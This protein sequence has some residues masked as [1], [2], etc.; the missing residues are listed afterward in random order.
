MLL[1]V[2]LLLVLS[3]FSLG[4]YVVSWGGNNYGQLGIGGVGEPPY[5]TAP[6]TVVS[7]YTDVTISKIHVGLSSHFAVSSSGAAYCAGNNFY[8]QLGIDSYDDYESVPLSNEYAYGLAVYPTGPMTLAYNTSTKNAYGWGQFAAYIADEAGNIIIPIEANQEENFATGVSTAWATSFILTNGGVYVAGSVIT[9]E[10]YTVDT[11]AKLGIGASSDQ[12]TLQRMSFW[13]NAPLSKIY[14][15]DSSH[16]CGVASNYSLYCW[17]QNNFGQ[18]GIG[19]TTPAKIP[20]IVPFFDIQQL[21]IGQLVT[22]DAHTVVLTCGGKVYAWGNNTYGNL[23]QGYADTNAHPTP[24]LISSLSSLNIIEIVSSMS[25]VFARTSLNEWYVWGGS[26]TNLTLFPQSGAIL[27]PT[28]NPYFSSNGLTRIATNSKSEFA[29]AWN[30]TAPTVISSDCL[31]LVDECLLGSDDCAANTQ[32]VDTERAYLCLCGAGFTGDGI[33]EAAGGT[34]CNDIDE[35]DA[36][37]NV[38]ASVTYSNGTKE[39]ASCTNTLGSYYCT[40]PSGFQGDG[41]VN[42]TNCADINECAVGGYCFANTICSNAI[43]SYSCVCQSGFYQL[44]TTPC[45][46]I[47]V[48]IDECYTQQNPCPAG[49]Y[50]NNSAGA[51]NCPCIQGYSGSPC[52]DVNE[53]TGV[54]IC[55]S[56]SYCTNLPGTY[57]CQ[58]P[59][60]YTGD[61]I[62][63]SYSGTGCTDINECNIAGTCSPNA[64]CV[65]SAGSYSC[66]CNTGYTGNGTVCTEINECAGQNNCSTGSTCTNIPGSYVCG[67]PSGYSGNGIQSSVSGGTGCTDINECTT[68]NNCSSLATCTNTPGSYNCTCGTNYTGNGFICYNSSL[69]CKAGY[70]ANAT[71]TCAPCPAGTYSNKTNGQQC[72]PCPAGTYSTGTGKT[73]NATCVACTAN[74]YSTAGSTQCTTCTPGSTSVGAASSCTSCPAGQYGFQGV[75]KNCGVGY[76][77]S[78]GSTECP[79]CAPGYFTTSNTASSC[80]I[81]PAGTYSSGKASNCS[82]CPAGTYSAAGQ[83]YCTQCPPGT[84]ISSGGSSCTPCSPGYYATSAG[85]TSCSA[86]AEGTYANGN[87][88][89]TCTPCSPGTFQNQTGQATCMACSNWEYTD[90]SGSTSCAECYQGYAGSQQYGSSICLSCPP[91]TFRTAGAIPVCTPCYAGSANQ[92]AGVAHCSLCIGGFYAPTCGQTICYPA[93]PGT[94]SS[95]NGYGNSIS[96]Y[97]EYSTV[98]FGTAYFCY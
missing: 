72:T 21:Y 43:G 36:T 44:T 45:G 52:T 95:Y 71:T 79:P 73:T 84:A 12:L 64:S 60:G 37:P 77:S 97:C 90:Q 30:G 58:C 50:C 22:G 31:P 25:A 9:D 6:P 23:G 17:G 80:S 1:I 40:C 47:C 83:Y 29:F 49:S 8:G 82:L 4:S 59:S 24:V 19:T 89:T 5:P 63:A 66:T 67:C 57:E 98:S 75:C 93:A 78:A 46:I 28:L 86:C 32:C 48:D 11:D 70:Y 76:F 81:C 54:N 94:Y 7:A 96:P 88:S 55:A 35:C 62:D 69:T 87:G 34:G 92:C 91:G 18:L 20:T 51:Y 15:T 16:V 38:C 65:N 3:R 68:G 41:K 85:S 26:T 74:T 14:S 56:K 39:I 10:G 53:C 13:D 33:S 42:G 27:M 61:G 2:T